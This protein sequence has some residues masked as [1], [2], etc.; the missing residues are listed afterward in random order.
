MFKFILFISAAVI[1]VASAL[2]TL[3]FIVMGEHLLA[4]VTSVFLV[5][6]FNMAVDMAQFGRTQ[7]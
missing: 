6:S 5:T 1:A 3:N 7:Q 4:A 2:H